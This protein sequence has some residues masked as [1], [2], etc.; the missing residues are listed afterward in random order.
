MTK[1]LRCPACGALWRVKDDLDETRLR[2]TECQ[3]VFAAD[4]MESV[5]VPDDK[6]NDRLEAVAAAQ[7]KSSAD[8]A[9]GEA[10]MT[11]LASELSEFDSRTGEPVQDPPPEPSRSSRAMLWGAVAVASA[12]V[13]AATGLLYG[14]QSVL[15]NA[16]QLRPVYEKVCTTLPC[17]GFV[18]QN[19]QAFKVVADI[20]MP[21]EGAS[22][23]DREIARRMPVIVAKLRN[24]SDLPQALPLLEMKLLDIAGV[25]MAQRVLEPSDY[26]FTG[27]GALMPGDTATVR[28]HLKDPLPYDAASARVSAI[29]NQL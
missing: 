1:V 14:H 17:P 24:D 13:I 27:A 8:T 21:L 28:L 20:E 23:A 12:C 26:G 19:A 16:P 7:A 18:W 10:S 29:S 2:C 3:A 5:I 15:N 4:K 22:D 6:L 9:Q 25:V 11:A